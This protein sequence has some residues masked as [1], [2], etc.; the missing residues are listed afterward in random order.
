MRSSLLLTLFALL[1]FTAC[2]EEGESV[3]V[4]TGTVPPPT[5]VTP[6]VTS[7]VVTQDGT[8]VS[9]VSVTGLGSA[10]TV[11]PDGTVTINA[12]QL[13]PNGTMVTV[14]SPGFWPENRVLMPGPNGADLRETFVMEPK[15]KAGDIDP[16]TGGTIELG[17]NF[18]VTLPENTI[19]TKEDGT[20]YDGVVEVYVN[21]DAPED[22]DEM[23][24][25]AGNAL[26]QMPDGSM[27]A[28][29]SYGMMDIALESPSGEPLVL[30]ES[31]KAEV[32]MPIDQETE[33]RGPDEVPFWVLDPA[34][35]W[36]PAGVARLAPGCYVVY[37]VSSGT[38]N[39]DIPHPTARLCGRF[40]DTGGFPLTHSPFAVE[41]VGGMLCGAS[42][43]DCNGE[44][45]INVAAGVLMELHV[46]DP[47]TGEFAVIPVDS[48]ALNETLDMGD[49][50]VDLANPA[51][52]ALVTDCSG[53]GLPDVALTEIW[54][55]GYGGNDGEYFA[56]AGDGQTVVSLATCDEEI[57]VQAFTNDFRAASPVY[58]RASLD[59]VPQTF[60]VCGELDA[61][62]Y[63]TLTIDGTDVPVTE[64]APIYWPDNEEFN[65][66]VRAAGMLDGQEYSLFLKFSEPRE[67]AYAGADAFAAIYRLSPGQDYGEGQVYVDPDQEIGLEGVSVSPE[68]DVFEGVFNAR[69][70]L[71]NDATQTVQAVN[72]PVNVSFRIKL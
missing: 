26:A 32:R 47:C 2:R 44:F 21:H 7:V 28:L 67:G 18:S 24:N 14:S 64:L 17:D 38:C 56:P 35:F 3:T 13:D 58:R 12:G 55:N 8:P 29:E 41:L 43:I 37:V 23:L 30:D 63:F 48:I 27:A 11:N 4:T 57:V 68:D 5:I 9:N 62:E 59:H 20:P 53:T 42:R 19:V 25:S 72:V 46:F 65:W 40:V 33:Q 51:F 71:Q 60:V 6:T 10:G 36:L 22:F 16:T 61:D 31:T 70:N 45:C 15:V 49:I 69:M 1:F 39:I 34:G 52:F 50:V 66:Q 54:A